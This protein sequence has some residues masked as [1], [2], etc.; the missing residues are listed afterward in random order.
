[1]GTP[2]F[3]FFFF[4]FNIVFSTPFVMVKGYLKSPAPGRGLW[5][6]TSLAKWPWTDNLTSV[7]SSVWRKWPYSSQGVAGKLQGDTHA[8]TWLSWCP[9]LPPSNG[10]VASVHGLWFSSFRDG[11]SL[12]IENVPISLNKLVWRQ[13]FTWN[14]LHYVEKWY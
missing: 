4:F 7:F 12:A 14:N 2:I 6:N 8:H 10:A 11:F 3:L 5:I 13:K 9:K 1:M